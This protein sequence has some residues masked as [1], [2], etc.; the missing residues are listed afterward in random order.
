MSKQRE[1]EKIKVNRAGVIA[2][3]ESM[4]N[5]SDYVATLEM[6]TDITLY[7]HF[8]AIINALFEDKEKD[9]EILLNLPYH[10]SRELIIP[11]YKLLNG[12]LILEGISNSS[13][14]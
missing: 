14:I 4:R 2:I 10:L 7:L 9:S 5:L 11:K 12:E 6:K 1:Q 13:N 3:E 8:E